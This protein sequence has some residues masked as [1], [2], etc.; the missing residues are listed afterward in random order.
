MLISVYACVGVKQ[1]HL[2][3]GWNYRT[4]S[5]MAVAVS[6]RLGLIHQM[7]KMPW[8]CM[9]HRVYCFHKLMRSN[10]KNQQKMLELSSKPSCMAAKQGKVPQ[11][12]LWTWG[13]IDE[14]PAHMENTM[15][16]Y[17]Q[18]MWLVTWFRQNLTWKESAT[19]RNP[20]TNLWYGTWPTSIFRD[21]RYDM[22]T[23]SC[24]QSGA[25]S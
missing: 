21:E 3:N 16:V 17:T 14:W 11:G 4:V 9:W 25:A 12:H 24:L 19:K 10:Q 6:S 20:S 5:G 22:R 23:V 13:I 18:V 7:D 1:I 2:D 8:E 15:M